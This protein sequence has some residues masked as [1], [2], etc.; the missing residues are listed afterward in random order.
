MTITILFLSS[1]SVSGEWSDSWSFEYAEEENISEIVTAEL[2]EKT[3]YETQADW[4][5]VNW[6]YYRTITINNNYIDNTLSNFPTL[7]VINSTIGAKCDGGDSIRFLGTDNSTEYFYEIEEWNAVGDSYIWVNLTSVTSTSDTIFLLYYNYSSATDNQSKNDVWDSNFLCVF[8]MNGTG[9]TVWDSTSNNNHGTKD[10]ATDPE[11]ATGIVGYG[12]DFESTNSE[13]IQLSTAIDGLSAMTLEGW[14]TTEDESGN[15]ESI[16][17]SANGNLITANAF[18][19]C[20]SQSADTLVDVI[21]DGTNWGYLVTD[22]YPQWTGYRYHTITWDNTS[23]GESMMNATIVGS[24]NTFSGTMNSPAGAVTSIGARKKD[25]WADFMDGVIDEVR[26]SNIKRNTTYI[27]TV[28]NN[29]NQTPGFL[30]IGSEQIQSATVPTVTT[31]AATGVEETNATL[32][33]TL[34]SNGSVDT[35]CWFL[36]GDEN[37]PTDNNVSQG[38]KA[39]GVTFTY[40]WSS[41]TPG[42]LYFVDTQANNSAGWDVSGGIEGFLTKPNAPTSLVNSSIPDGINVSW[43]LGTG[44]NRSVLLRKTGS[45]P[46]TPTDGT[47]VYNDTGNYTHDTSLVVGTNYYRV[48]EYAEETYNPTLIQFSD[49]YASMQYEQQAVFTAYTTLTF[50]GKIEVQAQA[51]PSVTVNGSAGVEETN[52]TLFGYLTRNE[53]EDSTCWFQCDKESNSFTSPERN[54]SVGVQPQNTNFSY[55]MTLLENGTFYYFRTAANNTN[56]WNNSVSSLYFLTK[57]QAPTGLSITPITGGFN[58][59]WTHGDGYNTSYLIYNIYNNPTDRGNGSNIYSGANNYYEHTG[60]TA[61]QTYYYGVWEY[62]TWGEP[63][64]GKWSDSFDAGNS[65]YAGNQPVFYSESPTNGSTGV[66]TTTTTWNIT[67]ESPTGQTFNWTIQGLGDVGANASNDD[68]NGSKVINITGNL[69]DGSTYYIWVNASETTNDNWSRE[70]YLFTTQGGNFTAYTT[71]T[72]GGK[73]DVQGTDPVISSPQ[74]T[75][76]SSSVE[77]YPWLNITVTDPQSETLNVTWSTNA[78]GSWTYTNTSVAS[79]TTVR[80]RATFANA[81]ATEYWWTVDVNDSEGGTSNATYYFTTDTYSWGNWS[82]WWTFNYTC[83]GPTN[84]QANTYNNSCINLTWSLCTDGADSNVLLVNE[85][86][87]VSYPLTPTNGTEIYNG[88]EAFYNHTG[89]GNGTSYYYTIWGYNLTNNNYSIVNET[90]SATTQGEMESY[91][92]YPANQSTGISRP[93]ANISIWVNGT[94]LDIYIYFWNMTPATNT[95]TLLK[96]W[97]G[98]GGHYE[99]SN[100]NL[101]A[102]GTDFLW[103]D[104]QYQWWVNI[105]DGS[106]WYNQSYWYNTTGS[107]YDVTN[108]GDVVPG[109]V[110]ADWVHRAPS[111]YIGIYDVDSTGDVVPT[112]ISIIWANKT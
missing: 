43:T 44:H 11:Q 7:V 72:F 22:A 87:W 50:G 100:T 37:P 13:K 4:W 71:L 24:D 31:N 86:G 62:A 79:G 60:L 99:E 103:G 74:P 29:T 61:G 42:K 32:S 91:G 5:N 38:V 105:T 111:P 10:G 66:L 15:Q 54:V 16:I 18:E 3:E 28:F 1:I 68:T 27:D 23:G 40:N 94:G 35:T 48:W 20:W 78:T 89:L 76:G 67:I 36:Y 51:V 26:I 73:I 53:S 2:G 107:R 112:D 92:P 90:T 108:T 102:R 8:H 75:N 109:D 33:G 63:A 85:S 70:L 88:T 96:H 81:S 106:E 65:T 57:P 34:T 6:N 45:Y 56:G 97:S 19:M 55:D 93:P 30:T 21:S 80:Q 59:S 41:L 69:S 52:A 77:M 12:Q 98:D 84:L 58:V 25:V 104:T 83:C 46:T 9:T 82:S 64:L 17:A 95:S 49:S 14:V 101:T 110:S 39:Q 47:V